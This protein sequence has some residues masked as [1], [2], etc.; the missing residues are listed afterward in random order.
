[1]T[2][3]APGDDGSSGTASEYDIRYSQ[4]P[5]DESSWGLA[6]QIS[7]LIP[8]P[9][10]A[11]SSESTQATGLDPDTDY[12][13]AIK[14]K[15]DENNWSVISENGTGHTQPGADMS[16]PRITN[17]K[18]DAPLAAGTKQTEIS[19]ITTESAT[20]R[21]SD[22]EGI[23]FQ[24][25]PEEFLQGNS[26]LQHSSLIDGLSDGIMIKIYVKCEDDSGNVNALDYV[27]SIE[28]LDS[29]SSQISN[30]ETQIKVSGGCST[31]INGSSNRYSV[32]IIIFICLLYVRSRRLS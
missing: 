13:F 24:I 2:W 22:I 21:Y 4:N 8:I 28:V 5:I 26:S 29:M 31:V 3:I 17:I 23:D 19:F 25:M 20:C 16:A 11:G 15:D 1:L 9:Q 12:Y 14:T 27:I 30:A 6:L 7:G 10:I 32:L 18:P